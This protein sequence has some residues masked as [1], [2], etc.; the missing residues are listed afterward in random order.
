MHWQWYDIFFLMFAMWGVERFI[1]AR[2]D[3][4]LRAAGLPTPAKPKLK[5]PPNFWRDA[6]RYVVLNG[7][8]FGGLVA[9]IHFAPLADDH[10]AYVVFL[11]ILFVVVAGLAI[12]WT[13]RDLTA[14]ASTDPGPACCRAAAWL[15]AMTIMRSMIG[16]FVAVLLFASSAFAGVL[17]DAIAAYDQ[18]DY[19]TALRL[20]QPL[21]EKGDATAQVRLGIVYGEG[22]GVPH[23]AAEA[24][25]WVRKAADQGDAY[26]QLWLG[27]LL[28][29]IGG[30]AAE[31]DTEAAKW[32]RKAADH[33]NVPAQMMLSDMYDNGLVLLCHKHLR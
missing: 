4:R 22:T 11:P 28:R 32:V 17:E 26:G 25:K 16:V 2:I 23:D 19:A 33:G 3:E 30:V 27:A 21:A 15:I 7:L 13:R 10:P 6:R 8:L 9:F 31:D 20:V 1:D 12:F 18:K 29:G 24:L 14:P 5:L